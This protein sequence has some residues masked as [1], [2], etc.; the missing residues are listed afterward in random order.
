MISVNA[1]HWLDLIDRMTAEGNL[2]GAADAVTDLRSAMIIDGLARAI[3]DPAI[4]YQHKVRLH[5]MAVATLDATIT[6][7]KARTNR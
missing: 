6:N 1:G 7:L 3:D 4:S 2:A 5:S